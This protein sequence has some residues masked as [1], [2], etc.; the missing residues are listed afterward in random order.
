MYQKVVHVHKKQRKQPHF[1]G[2]NYILHA[3]MGGHTHFKS[4]FHQL[5][6]QK[7]MYQSSTL[8]TINFNS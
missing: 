8:L 4:R 7:I 3:S 1:L 2:M 6:G 5:D